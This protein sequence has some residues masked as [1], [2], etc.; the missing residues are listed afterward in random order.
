MKTEYQ[1]FLD[2]LGAAGLDDRKLGQ[3]L[4]E[5]AD[6]PRMT[7]GAIAGG[8]GALIM[9]LTVEPDRLPGWKISATAIGAGCMAYITA[10]DH[11][12]ATLLEAFPAVPSKDAN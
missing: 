11:F 7:M 12:K 3:L 10:V 4:T 5:Y 9:A 2:A 1:I 8:L 6:D